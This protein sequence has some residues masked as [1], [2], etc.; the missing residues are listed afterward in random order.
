MI[1][2]PT[3]FSMMVG[4][5]AVG[6]YGM[7]IGPGVWHYVCAVLLGVVFRFGYLFATER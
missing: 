5:F 6:I 7:T 4:A 3:A 2:H 1:K